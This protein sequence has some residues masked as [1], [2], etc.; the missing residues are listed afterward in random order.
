MYFRYPPLHFITIHNTCFHYLL[1]YIAGGHQLNFWEGDISY[2]EI[3]KEPYKFNAHSGVISVF[4]GWGQTIQP[5]HVKK[6][7]YRIIY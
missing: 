6:K 3:F 5:A 4:D 7:V 2:S 1:K